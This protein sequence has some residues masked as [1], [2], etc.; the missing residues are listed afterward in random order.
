[1]RHSSVD[2]WLVSP[3]NAQPINGNTRQCNENSV[4]QIHGLFNARQQNEDHAEDDE[5]DGQCKI[6]FDWPRQI[7]S[8]IWE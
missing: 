8:D 6:D 2:C 3:L 5:N 1:M 4:D 7:G